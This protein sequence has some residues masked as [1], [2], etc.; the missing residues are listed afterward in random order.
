LEQETGL[1]AG[2]R[3]SGRII[4]LPKPHL[5]TIALRHEADACVNWHQGDHRFFW[6]VVNTPPAENYFATEFAVAGY[7]HDTLAARLAPRALVALLKTW[8]LGR[9]NVT[10]LEETAVAC[11]DPASGR[12]TLSGGREIRFGY[13]FVAAGAESFPILESLMPPMP[14]PLGQGV[15]GQA[16]LLDAKLD[17]NLP[18]AFLDGLYVV[19][20]EDGRV[21]VGS[22]SENRYTDPASTDDQLDSI[23][24]RARALMPALRNASVIERWAGL[25]PKAIGRD[26][27]IGPMPGRPNVIA[28]TG[29]FKISFGMAHKLAA[30]ALDYALGNIP[31]GLPANFTLAGQVEREMDVK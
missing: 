12:A 1:T 16:A 28:L 22:T 25:R 11:L 5:R 29:G 24:V 3:R 7:V 18:V 6:H 15:K 19:P 26:P 20:H 13:A 14:K 9:P 17:P 27:M 8:L 10:L 21:A 30:A 31:A 4:P 2:F 23:V